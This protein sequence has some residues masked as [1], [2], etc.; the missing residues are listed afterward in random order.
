MSLFAL[1][2]P[3]TAMPRTIGVWLRHG[4]FVR[5]AA[6]AMLAGMSVFGGC[7][8]AVED[9]DTIAYSFWGSVEQA[10]TERAVIRAF[11]EAN[12]GVRVIAQHIPGGAGR[13]NDKLQAMLVGRV[14]PDVI[15]IEMSRYDEWASRKVLADVTEVISDLESR[16][17]LMPVVR[18][19]FQRDG[20]YFAVPVNCHATATYV[21]LDAFAQAG[22]EIPPEG[23]TWQQLLEVV[24]RLSRRAGATDVATD[25]A[26][27]LPFP[28]ILF[29]SFGGQLFDNPYRPTRV[30]ANSPEAID[31]V[32]FMRAMVATGGV[33]L[34]G[35][36][37]L[38][39][40]GSYQFFRDGRLAIFF[41]G[42][43]STPQ[44]MG[45]TEFRWDVIP[46]PAGPAGAISQHGGT[47][48]GVWEGS[49]RQ[50]LARRFIQFYASDEAI[51]VTMGG[52]RYVPVVRALAEGP[53]FL[54]LTPPDSLEVFVRTM[55]AGAA[56][57]VLY[58]PGFGPVR[59]HFDSAMERALVRPNVPA[60]V[61]VEDLQRELERWLNRQAR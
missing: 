44:F 38:A 4:A 32:E 49:P 14:A 43:W 53:E 59:R 1:P 61:I 34:P 7:K 21:N 19:A 48:L 41:S 29:W 57:A 17:E 39:D 6:A 50:E 36:G 45:V 56:Q 46:I 5:L 28:T 8:R 9:G 27:Q 47:A 10:E 25:F 18:Q 26:L 37:S 20:S 13:Y 35:I 22:I 54:A 40:Q 60:E 15:M 2:S 33:L 16:H 30:L 42:R 51:N 58:A 11:E 31:A 23:F 12:P 24:P 3:P 55:E 52:R